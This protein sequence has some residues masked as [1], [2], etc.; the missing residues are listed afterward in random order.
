[1]RKVKYKTIYLSRALEYSRNTIDYIRIEHN[2]VY[3]SN[4]SR[5]WKVYITGDC[6]NY[7]VAFYDSSKDR[8]YL[9]DYP[10]TEEYVYNST[11]FCLK[12]DMYLKRKNVCD[13]DRVK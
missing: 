2:A 8:Y 12:L 7:F 3:T 10:D 5:L 1:M 4:G 9:S 11:I 13:I 6:L